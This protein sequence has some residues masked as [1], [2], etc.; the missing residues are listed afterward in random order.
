MRKKTKT[1]SKIAKALEALGI[2]GTLENNICAIEKG[3]ID[4][5]IYIDEETETFSVMQY[6][7]GL[8]GTLTKQEFDTSLEVTKEF[9]KEYDGDWNDGISYFSSPIYC[10]K[11]IK[12]L[13][14]EQ[15]KRII[16]DFFEVWLFMCANTCAI[17]DE[18]I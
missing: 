1:Y 18:T 9:H 8:R 16:D 17:T 10:L 11:G 13:P 14:E 5:L 6:V 7:T 2:K 15:L 12:V 4:Y 3:N